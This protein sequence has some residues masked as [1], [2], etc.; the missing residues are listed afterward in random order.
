MLYTIHNFAVPVTVP[1]GNQLTLS[2]TIFDDAIRSP[3]GK[4]GWGSPDIA[5]TENP[6][7]GSISIKSTFTGGYSGGGQF[8]TWGNTPL[9]TA[10]TAYVAFSV[11]GGTGTNGKTLIINFNGGPQAY[12]T[13]NEGMWKDV[14]VALSDIGSP[15]SISE[16]SFQDGNWAGVV[17]IDQIGLK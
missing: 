14:K 7:V 13:I 11:F 2:A 16:I 5:N 15:A 17:Y 10:G 9:S 3:F 12:V 1:F 6:R 4:G 8:G